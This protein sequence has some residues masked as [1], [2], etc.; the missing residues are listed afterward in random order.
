MNNLFAALYNPDLEFNM[1]CLFKLL[2]QIEEIYVSLNS[3][4][5]TWCISKPNSLSIVM[6]VCKYPL[7]SFKA[8]FFSRLLLAEVTG[9]VQAIHSKQLMSRKISVNQKFICFL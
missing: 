9:I 8:V 4:T 3:T 7:T 6:V 1:I 2:K 5:L